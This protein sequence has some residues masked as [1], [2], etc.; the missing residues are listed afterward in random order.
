VLAHDG[1]LYAVGACRSS[2]YREYKG[3]GDPYRNDVTALF[4]VPLADA[5]APGEQAPVFVRPERKVSRGGAASA[6]TLD[7]ASFVVGD[8]WYAVVASHVV[9]A[10]RPNVIA[11][12]PGAPPHI[13]GCVMVE[14]GVLLVVDLPN[15]LDSSHRVKRSH[16]TQFIVMLRESPQA[17]PFGLLVD[18][19]GDTFEVSRSRLVSTHLAQSEHVLVSSVVTPD[20][21][22]PND[23]LLLLLSSERLAACGR[24]I[25]VDQLTALVNPLERAG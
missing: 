16:Q 21:A 25:S 6:D 4:F 23:A 12:M 24:G 2:G 17:A 1:M 11:T 9:E 14:H 20:P 8:K 3:D 19:L 13:R 18:E 5:T 22:T 15:L 7:L 10:I